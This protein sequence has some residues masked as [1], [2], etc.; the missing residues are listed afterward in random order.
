MIKLQGL[1]KVLGKIKEMVPGEPQ[2]VHTLSEM[3]PSAR[4]V[5]EK[6]VNLKKVYSM[7]PDLLPPTVVVNAACCA[8][9]MDNG[10][11]PKGLE[12]ELK[13]ALSH[14][15]RST[16][17]K[18]YG[19]L[20]SPP[21]PPLLLAVRPSPDVRIPYLAQTVRGVG[22]TRAAISWF[23]DDTTHSGLMMDLLT[24]FNST[25]GQNVKH[26]PPS[27][28][29]AQPTTT[30]PG[31]TP[32]APDALA[33]PDDVLQAMQVALSDHNDFEKDGFVQLTT[34]LVA[35]FDSFAGTQV[36]RFRSIEGLPRDGCAV[37][38]QPLVIA[39]H[40][41]VVISRDPSTGSKEAVGKY[42]DLLVRPPRMHGIEELGMPSF[43]QLQAKCMNLERSF[44]DMVDVS[45]AHTM[46]DHLVVLQARP[47]HRSPE[48]SVAAATALAKEGVTTPSE[49]LMA[50]HAS[51]FLKATLSAP[52]ATELLGWCNDYARLAVLAGC[53]SSSS[54]VDALSRGADGLVV[55]MSQM[56]GS[57][58]G[59]LH[60]KTAHQ[61]TGI[62]HQLELTLAGLLSSA[63]VG[64][65]DGSV[66]FMVTSG[67]EDHFSHELNP[68]VLKT[69][70]RAIFGALHAR[71]TQQLIP[72]ICSPGVFCD[73]EVILF[74]TLCVQ[75]Q[76]EKLAPTSPGGDVYH[77]PF[78]LA[79]SIAT[80]RA[81]I[82]AASI[83]DV[84]G[85][86]CLI[87]DTD[88]LTRLVYGVDSFEPVMQRYM[89]ERV[90]T[91]SPQEEIDPR[92]VAPLLKVL[93]K[94]CA[95][96]PHSH[97]TATLDHATHRPHTTTTP[98]LRHLPQVRHGGSN[99]RPAPPAP[100]D[101]RVPLHVGIQR[102]HRRTSQVSRRALPG[103]SQRAAGQTLRCSGSHRTAPAQVI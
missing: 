65:G 61:L 72:T 62:E 82:Q 49:A 83:A 24:N 45:W 20:E 84:H 7:E 100:A 46:D 78:Q 13:N 56:L 71:R 1:Q 44:A 12:R 52:M 43:A 47:A 90:V 17:T 11:L 63:S 79:A 30:S 95:C 39:K 103:R 48:A 33:T 21:F 88:A 99:C 68:E 80:P 8:Y 97:L 70:L 81:C 31:G 50:M 73:Q 32:R 34:A 94:R 3:S 18:L 36:Q 38:L 42:R 9:Y 14:F 16:G 66:L 5:G 74:S 25:Y 37:V 60:S 101:A 4:E 91:R 98:L 41:G 64:G 53:T 51:D 102:G 2:Y 6:A 19:A 59:V 76:E 75:A 35:I 89:H 67:S 86:Q 29:A 69:Q 92:G 22:L 96:S 27:H 77:V 57:H 87:I 40:V 55:D 26:M 54:A 93:R 15:E 23:E 85:V 28:F 58:L 10:H